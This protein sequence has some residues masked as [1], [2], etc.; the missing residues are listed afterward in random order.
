MRKSG[1]VA[2]LGQETSLIGMRGTW[3]MGMRS[4]TQIKTPGVL[5]GALRERWI[6]GPEY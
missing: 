5:K 4:G 6:C 3:S 1:R 2:R